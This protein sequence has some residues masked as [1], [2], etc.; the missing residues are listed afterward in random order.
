MSEPEIAAGGGGDGDAPADVARAR[1]MPTSGG[2]RGPAGATR[3]LVLPEPYDGSGS[4]SEW[5]FHFENVAAV[6]NWD[7]A[8][9]LQWLRVRVTGRAQKALHRL[10]GSTD[11][12]YEATRDALKARFDP[13][14][15]RTR[16]QAEF[17]T[18]RKKA[19]EGWADFADELR[20]LADKAYPDLGEDA[21]ERLSINAYLTQLPQPQIA[22]SVRQKQPA[23]LDDAVTATLEMESYLPPQSLSV[24][25]IGIGGNTDSVGVVGQVAQLTH[26]VEELTKQMEQ[27]KHSGSDSATE[28]SHPAQPR[29]WRGRR[30]FTGVCWNCGKP[31]HVRRNCPDPPQQQPGNPGQQQGKLDSSSTVDLVSGGVTLKVQQPEPITISPVAGGYRLLATLNGTPIA[32]LIDTGAAVTL[33]RQ[34]VWNQIAAPKPELKPWPGPPLVSAGG[35]P[36]TIHGCMCMALQLGGVSIETEMVVVSPLTSEAILGIDFLQ[37]QQAMIDL[38]QG[39]LHLRQSGCD[40]SLG[41][42]S[43]FDPCTDTQ[44]VRVTTT[45]TVPARTIMTVSAHSEKPVQG[46]WLVEEAPAKQLHLAVG[47]AVVEP[48]SIDVPVRLLNVSDEPVTIYA[49]AVVATLQPVELPAS[50]N[51]ADCGPDPEVGA[52]KRELLWD[53]VEGCSADLT[54]GERD[55][56][57]SLLLKHA[58]VFAASTADLGRTNKV[59]HRIDTGT[60]RPIRQPVRRISPH[61]REEVKTL[62]E[63]MLAKGVVEPSSSPWASPV[64][65]VRKKDG[66]MRFCIDYRKLNEVTKK[67]AYPLPRI[68]TTLDTLHGSRWFTA[69]DL[70]SGYWQ[71]EV[72]EA[73][74]AKTAFCTPGGLFQFR[75]MPFGLCNAPACFQR[76]MDLVLSGMQ[77]SQCLV[78]LDDI[79]VLGSSFESHIQNLDSVFQRLREAGLRLK[80]AKCAFFRQEVQYLGHIISREG[81][82]TDP[83][84][85]RKVAAWPVPKSKRETQQFI[86]FANYYRRFI[87]DFAQ[88]AR[89]LHRLT[90]RTAPFTWTQECQESFDRLREC[91]CSAPILAYPDF[92][93][94]FILDTDASDTGLGGVLSQ[95]D[96][97]GRERVIAY[98]SRLLTKPERKYCVTRRELLAAVTF[99]QQY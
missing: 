15:R 16:Y 90:E 44:Q 34:D 60:A 92:Q 68:D 27:L 42:P 61:H 35:T 53:L 5:S 38:G 21:R 12:T 99:I 14:S 30:F 2:E 31:G 96:D 86:G 24:V 4:W 69:L 82:A 79:I 89:P 56:F 49:G 17:Q 63:Q 22:F 3:P 9:K 55:I 36:L 37:T 18:R 93:R 78:Y 48:L 91:L 40:I 23:T 58:D 43:A 28:N 45:I 71:V 46:V 29:P 81:V 77:W 6:N 1:D 8:Q 98:G 97:Q 76:L 41:A 47:R 7:D 65:L 54:G 19:S 32:L 75:V 39:T 88:L 74:R 26:A 50:V 64:V 25:D 10:Q 62:L 80:P 67:D 66:S 85:V 94:P 51:V 84:K 72:E 20:S 59:H 73:D 33:L 83:E 70:L 52:D 13:E 57:F 95:A 87:K 11:M